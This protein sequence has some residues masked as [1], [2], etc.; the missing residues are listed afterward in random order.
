VDPRSAGEIRSALEKL[1]TTPSLQQ[2]LGAAGRARAEQFR[3]RNSAR[4]SLDFF[5][6]LA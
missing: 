1:L 6:K 5:R 3:W 2:Q 4:Q